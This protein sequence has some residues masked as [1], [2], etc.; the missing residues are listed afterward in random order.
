MRAGA[1]FLVVFASVVPSRAANASE[2]VYISSC[3]LGIIVE[4]PVLQAPGPCRD[5]LAIGGTWRVDACRDALLPEWRPFSRD[6]AQRLERPGAPPGTREALLEALAHA[7]GDPEVPRAEAAVE[8]LQELTFEGD[9]QDAVS[10]AAEEASLSHDVRTRARIAPVLGY[11]ETSSSMQRLIEMLE[12]DS[13]WVRQSAAEAFG[14]VDDVD[15]LALERLR[16][17]AETLLLAPDRVAARLE[18]ACELEDDEPHEA[19]L[20]RHEAAPAVE[21]LRQLAWT[22][23]GERALRAV[24]DAAEGH[25]DPHLRALAAELRARLDPPPPPEPEGEPAAPP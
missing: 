15:A 1:G 4:A 3:R 10:R 2:D 5:L 13:A 22:D 18:D 24:L 9:L 16:E 17:L 23:G 25:D 12:D 21:A 19:C 11:A 8:L 20:L 14:E 6:L 7:V